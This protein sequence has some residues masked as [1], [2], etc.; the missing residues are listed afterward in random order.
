MNGPLGKSGFLAAFSLIF[1][2]EIG[3]KTFFIAALLAMKL[4][5]WLSFAGSLASLSV[6]TIISVGI[7]VVIGK[8]PDAL[9]SSVPVGE[10]LGIIMLVFFGLKALHE[11]LKKPTS[12]PSGADEEM[13]EADEAVKAAEQGGKVRRDSPIQAFI[14][15]ASLIFI[16]EWGDRS[17]L[18]TIALGASQNPVGVVAGAVLG[19]G[20]ATGIAVVGGALA[21]QHVSE[22]QINIISGVLFL[23]FAVATGVSMAYP[24]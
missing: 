4:G 19:H 5:K 14:Q 17:M 18:A 21:A 16:A 22:K 13:A 23:V 24:H 6:M 20:L 2:S 1:V 3:D 9:K 12:G 8:V 11:G 7:G 10:I 15:V